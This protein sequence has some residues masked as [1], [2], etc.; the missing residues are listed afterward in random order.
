MV[1]GQANVTVLD[2]SLANKKVWMLKVLEG[3]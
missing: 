2:E 1:N 3:D